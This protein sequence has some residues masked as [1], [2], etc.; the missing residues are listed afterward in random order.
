[1]DERAFVNQEN[2][3]ANRAFQKVFSSTLILLSTAACTKMSGDSHGAGAGESG[4]GPAHSL[5]G[6]SRPVNSLNNS[7]ITLF[8]S[9]WKDSDGVE[10]FFAKDGNLSRGDSKSESFL[11]KEQPLKWKNGS[12]VTIFWND[13]AKKYSSQ[14]LTSTNWILT[15]IGTYK[16]LS[17]TVSGQRYDGDRWTAAMKDAESPL[18][19]LRGKEVP[20]DQSAIYVREY[21]EQPESYF[22]EFRKSVSVDGSKTSK[23]AAGF[24]DN[25]QMTPDEIEGQRDNSL[26]LPPPNCLLGFSDGSFIN[27][28]NKNISF[29]EHDQIEVRTFKTYPIRF[30]NGILSWSATYILLNGNRFGLNYIKVSHDSQ[31]ETM[32]SIEPRLFLPTLESCLGGRLKLMQKNKD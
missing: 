20:G 16:I 28:A 10:Y 4:Q 6:D 8:T 30:G 18:T 15:E 23:G 17:L 29:S 22:L 25:K 27:S 24:I 32:P 1:M 14:M 13:G 3:L 31:F 21:G 2:P 26:L 9:I 19:G 11:N 7:D 5:Y 12:Q